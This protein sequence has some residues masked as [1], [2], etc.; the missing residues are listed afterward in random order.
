MVVSFQVGDNVVIYMRSLKSSDRLQLH[1]DLK[2][3]MSP[4]LLIADLPF[5]IETLTKRKDQKFNFGAI[6]SDIDLNNISSTSLTKDRDHVHYI[7]TFFT[8]T[9]MLSSYR[10]LSGLIR[11]L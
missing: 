7:L 4:A 2:N 3:E 11:S 1:I 6:V 9:K 5:T 8:K 10:K